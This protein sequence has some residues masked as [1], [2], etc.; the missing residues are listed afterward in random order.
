MNLLQRRRAMMGATAEGP[1]TPIFGPCTDWHFSSG[2]SQAISSD[3]FY[4]TNTSD[5]NR[6]CY[7]RPTPKTYTEYIGKTIVIEF[8]NDKPLRL[9]GFGVTK[10][11]T[12]DAGIGEIVDRVSTEQNIPAGSHKFKFTIGEDYVATTYPQRYLTVYFFA[13]DETDTS[14]VTLSDVNIYVE[15][16]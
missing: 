14:R 6:Y 10:T 2:W 7:A 16:E 11:S 8:T 1:K 13:Y 12:F 4:L 3:S 5:W 9:L 15:G